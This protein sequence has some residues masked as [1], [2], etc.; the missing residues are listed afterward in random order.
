MPALIMSVVPVTQTG[1]ANGVNALMRSVGTSLATAV[2][3]MVLTGSVVLTPTTA[4]PVVTPSTGA[5]ASTAVICLV[6]CALAVACA[7]A[8]PRRRTGATH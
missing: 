1:E 7:L 2:V 6:V 4:G 5:Y 3:G 8:I